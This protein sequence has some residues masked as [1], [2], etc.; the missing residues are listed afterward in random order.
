MDSIDWSEIHYFEKAPY[1][2]LFK[3]IKQK[4]RYSCLNFDVT[5]DFVAFLFLD[6]DVKNMI[7]LIDYKYKEV[8]LCIN[9]E[10]KN[11]MKIM[12]K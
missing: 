12:P 7:G 10:L 6:G 2:D 9:M 3:E 8:T 5:L 4:K 11:G 1:R